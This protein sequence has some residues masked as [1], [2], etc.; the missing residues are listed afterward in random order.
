MSR[1]ATIPLQRTISDAIQRAQGQLAVTQVRL[2]T[3][4]KAANFADLGT[5]SIRNLSAH[6][7][8]ARQ[9]AHTAV[10]KNVG[11]TLSLYQANIEGIQTSAQDLKQ[12]IVSAIGTGETAGLQ[13]QIQTSFDQYRSSLNASE[14]GL[15]LFGGS[16]TGSSFLPRTLADAAATDPANAFADDT[17]RATARVAEGHDMT[18]GIGATAIGRDLYAAFRTLAQAG[19][20][21]ENP[22]AAQIDALKQAV[23]QLNTG[24]GSV[25]AAN[26]DN[27]RRQA[28][29]DTLTARGEQRSILLS[30]VIESNEDADLGQVAIDLAQQ[31]T[32]LQASYSVFAQLSSLSLVNYLK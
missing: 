14:G 18:Y 8:L 26:A 7:M 25:G 15:P 4:K 27:G 23:A 1:V 2:S 30:S 19:T 13:E 32:V 9:T 12:A 5:E 16:Q 6:S 20:I 24:L 3:G 21:G 22:S 17:V 31:K 11:T 10:A 29:L 28:S